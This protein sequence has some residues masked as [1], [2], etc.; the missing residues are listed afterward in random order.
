MC[1]AIKCAV[2]N[3]GES[4]A[5]LLPTIVDIILSTYYVTPDHSLLELAKQVKRLR[6]LEPESILIV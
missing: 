6:D 2:S 4:C 1:F 5:E 3:L